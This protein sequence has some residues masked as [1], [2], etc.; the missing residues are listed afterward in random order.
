MNELYLGVGDR[1]VLLVDV[2][3]LLGFFWRLDMRAPFS[4]N[5]H[6]EARKTETPP[7]HQA[8]LSWRHL[9]IL[10]DIEPC[11]SK[12]PCVS[13]V[14]WWPFRA[15]LMLV[16]HTLCSR[17]GTGSRSA[18][19]T[20]CSLPHIS[21]IVKPSPLNSLCTVVTSTGTSASLTLD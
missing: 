18:F 7:R 8:A 11:G 19:V 2:R 9:Q 14:G 12:P 15:L 17:P 20:R 5:T 3:V 10:R 16:D 1:P 6:Q 21:A 13:N 4:T